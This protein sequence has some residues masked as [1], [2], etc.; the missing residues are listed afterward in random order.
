M[1]AGGTVMS[2]NLE[3]LRHARDL[4]LNGKNQEA[5][6]LLRENGPALDHEAVG[7]ITNADTATITRYIERSA[8]EGRYPDDPFPA[9]TTSTDP[10]PV[11]AVERAPALLAWHARHADRGTGRRRLWPERAATPTN[12]AAKPSRGKRSSE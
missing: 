1:T 5:V 2:N 11:W 3:L 10:S 9:P 12:A 6:A 7:I 4:L 8:D